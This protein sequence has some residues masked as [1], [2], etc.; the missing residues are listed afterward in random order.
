MGYTKNTT[1]LTVLD[2]DMSSA[3]WLPVNTLTDQKGLLLSGD[4]RYKTERKKM[5]VKVNQISSFQT[6]KLKNRRKATRVS[7]ERTDN[8]CGVQSERHPA[9]KG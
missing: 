6:T 7:S 9:E 5:E 4:S 3:N 1:N 2:I 8:V